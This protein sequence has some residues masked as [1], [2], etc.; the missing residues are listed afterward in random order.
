MRADPSTPRPQKWTLVLRKWEPGRGPEYGRPDDEPDEV[1]I[2]TWWEE[3]DGQEITDTE[4]IAAL[5]A[6]LAARRR[7]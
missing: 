5:E 7:D 6:E 4:R 3:P 1:T 2:R